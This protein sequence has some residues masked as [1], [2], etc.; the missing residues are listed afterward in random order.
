MN[1]SSHDLALLGH[2]GG[3]LPLNHFHSKKKQ[4]SAAKSVVTENIVKQSMKAFMARRLPQ[5]TMKLLSYFD[6]FKEP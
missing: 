3:T 1:I 4:V 6:E 5:I 2:G